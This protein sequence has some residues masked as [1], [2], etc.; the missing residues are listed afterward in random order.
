MTEE[1]KTQNIN[2]DPLKWQM[3]KE[4]RLAEEKKKEDE[5]EKRRNKTGLTQAQFVKEIRRLMATIRDEDYDPSGAIVSRA[6]LVVF[7]KELL[8]YRIKHKKEI[9]ALV[10]GLTQKKSI[11]LSESLVT[12]LA[13]TAIRQNVVFGRKV[14]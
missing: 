11:C 6:I 3:E 2:E 9:Q 5:R 13:Q 12:M 10:D 8:T 7:L 4:K 14:A 1:Q